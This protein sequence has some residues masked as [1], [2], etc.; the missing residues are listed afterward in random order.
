VERITDAIHGTLLLERELELGVVRDA[1]DRL[2]AGHGSMLLVEGAAGIGKTSLLAAAREL[3][4]DRD[5]LVRLARAGQLEREMPF[6]VARQL[7]EALI[8]RAGEPHR[9]R[10]LSGS[11]ALSL[12]AFGHT[13]SDGP[14]GEVDPFAPIHGLYWLLANLCDSQ[15]V[16]LVIDDA[17]WADS[18]SLRW[19]DYV[20]RRAPDTAV[21]IVVGARTGEADEPVELQPLRLDA[22]EVIRPCPLSG[23]AVDELITAEL[24][25]QPSSEFT[26]ACSRATGGNPFLLTEV[27]RTLRRTSAGPGAA[28]AE[29]ESLSPD[30]VA[31]S[32]LPRLRRFG[33]EAELVAEAIAV[34]GGAPQLRHASSLAG[35]S[36]ERARTLCDQLRNA[37][38]LASGHPIDFVHPLVR[39]AVYHELSEERRS[40]AHRR[41]AELLSSTG[42]TARDVAPHLM[43]CSPNG[44][45]WVVAQLRHAAQEAMRAGAPDAARRYL[46]RALQEPAVD[47]LEV[48]Y[49]LGRAMWG[50]SSL[51]APEILVSV[52]DRTDDADL[53][54]QAI[55]DAA[56]T[57]FDCGNLERAVHWLGRQVEATRSGEHRERMLSAEASLSCLRTMNVGRRP[58]DSK[59]IAAVVTG[60]G[61]T[62]RGELLVRQALSF[63]RFLACDP[64]EEVV[65]LAASF[66]PPP[67]AGRGAVPGFAC[68]VLAWSGRWELARDATSRGWES[69]RSSGLVHVASYRESAL[70]EIDRLSGR[71]LDAEAEARTAWDIT[72]DLAPVSL[73]A[74]VAITSLLTTLIARGRLDEA[75]ELAAGWDLSAPFS[76]VPISPVP[77]E[78][79]GSLRLARGQLE[80]GVEDLI[81]VGEDMDEL[82]LFN[83]AV[84]P[85]RQEVA[86]VLATLG[87]TAEARS[88]LVEGEKRAV[89]FGAPHVIGA[90][91][92][93]RSSIEPRQRALETLRASI[94]ALE[95]SGP[96]HELARSDLELG[97]TLRRTGQRR[98]CREPLRRALELAHVCGAGAL[99]QRAREELAAAGSRPRSVFRSGVE[100]LTASELR[101]AKLAA[102]GLGNVEIAQR[103][104][105]TRKTV[106]KHLGNAY[107]KLE[108]GSRK[109]LAAALAESPAE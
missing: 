29:L 22:G 89:S 3:V 48:T 92:R 42:G 47:E 41:A 60:S 28:G 24:G 56:W 76:L 10:L 94:S 93:A 87:R 33:P 83:P 80:D 88:I 63:D 16:L 61:A 104:F 97:T 79:R 107:T 55:E 68:K 9:S 82:R 99:A 50:A 45:R 25:A 72:R 65:D 101:A 6:G 77:L 15:P 78:I 71:L 54:L 109:E 73:P 39:T 44:D 57:Y 81:A 100:A 8:E 11:A 69:A 21:L 106:E 66:P 59:H 67:W 20:A 14:A 96:P 91:L 53:Q 98:E 84:V 13:D 58:D 27:L 51:D 23:A 74:L 103:L 38:I 4:G 35:V 17:H 5:V 34:L 86:P 37:E 32:V 12:I 43:A 52:A 90:M 70:A 31:D 7:L 108:I 49:E 26:E 64:V 62:T 2:V 40:D 46:E 18:Q 105:V 75:D 102:E 95:S 85:W 1:L 30:A 19:L 36:E